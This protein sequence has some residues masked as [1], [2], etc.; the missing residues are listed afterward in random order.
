MP[1]KTTLRRTTDLKMVQ[2]IIDIQCLNLLIK[3]EQKI[4]ELL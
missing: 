1:Q 4:R 3:M 2:L